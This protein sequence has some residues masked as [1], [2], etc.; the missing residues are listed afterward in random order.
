MDVMVLWIFGAVAVVVIAILWWWRRRR[1]SGTDPEWAPD[2]A[3]DA[4]P[5][6]GAATTPQ[7]FDRNSLVNRSRLLDPSKWDN[8]PD[9]EVDGEGT[10][11]GDLPRYLD[12]DYLR[13]QSGDEPVSPG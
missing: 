1:T 6:L 11:P 13:R 9:G 8:T 12:R 10:E 5:R 3:E 7:V 4:G 2:P